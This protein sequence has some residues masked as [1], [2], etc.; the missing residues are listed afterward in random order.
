MSWHVVLTLSLL[1][2]SS[3]SSASRTASVAPGQLVS[4]T[5]AD[6]SACRHAQTTWEP[7]GETCWYPVDLLTESGTWVVERQQRERWENA[8][9]R[10]GEYP[11]RVQRLRIRD[12][13]KVDL[14]VEDLERVRRESRRVAGLW[15]RSTPRRFSLPLT[16][17]LSRMPDSGRFG[18]RRVINGE[19]RNPHTGADYRA[20]A[21]T[22][23]KAAADGTVVLAEEHFFAGNSVYLDHGDGLITMYFHLQEL[24]VVTGQDVTAGQTI[25]RVGSTGRSTGPHLHFGARWRGARVDPELLLHP[26]RA[27]RL[28]D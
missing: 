27:P 28:E 23:V 10:I 21:G 3:G 12:R 1:T 4:W 6:T 5:G 20:D 25:G 18:A 24:L 16:P 13:S 9:V 2:L 14:S 19:P 11:Y 15:D 17:P 22:P 7:L 8:L 26:E